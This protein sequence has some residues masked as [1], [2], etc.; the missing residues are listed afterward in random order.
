MEPKKTEFI[1]MKKAVFLIVIVLII[2][3]L[4]KIWLKTHFVLGEEIKVLGLDW[5]R[6]HFLENNGMAWGT[7]FGGKNGKL[8][9][10]SFRLVAIVGIGY[11]LYDTAIKNSPKVLIIAIALIFAGA[12]GNI[13][14]SVFLS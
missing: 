3:Q 11:W 8:F 6:I 4:S 9:L 7:E 1:L 13:F 14:D 10:T 5:F 2:D 12:L